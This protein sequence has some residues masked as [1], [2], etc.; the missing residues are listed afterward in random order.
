MEDFPKLRND[1]TSNLMVTGTIASVGG[2]DTALHNE[3]N[4]KRKMTHDEIDRQR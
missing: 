4:G 2:D 3:G 1:E